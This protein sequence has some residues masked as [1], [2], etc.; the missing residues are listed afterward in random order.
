M[1][2]VAKPEKEEEKKR[3][4]L[5]AAEEDKVASSFLLRLLPLP[6]PGASSPPIMRLS[7]A[8]LSR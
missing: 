1:E 3:A 7:I 6:R 5:A 2:C 4:R 8:Y